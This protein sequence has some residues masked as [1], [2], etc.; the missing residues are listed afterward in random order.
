MHCRSVRIDDQHFAGTY[1]HRNN[2][3]VL[4]S[5]GSEPENWLLLPVLYNGECFS[6]NLNDQT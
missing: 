5:E 2:V 4:H 1:S 6:K 3:I